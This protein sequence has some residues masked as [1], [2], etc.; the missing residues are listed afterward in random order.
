MREILY[1]NLTSIKKRRR[2]IFVSERSENK[3]YKTQ[4]SKTFVY[5]VKRELQKNIQ[6]TQPIFYITKFFNSYTQE[7]KFILRVKGTFFVI[8]PQGFQEITFCHSMRI[9]IWP[10]KSQPAK[11]NE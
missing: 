1:K 8:R 3:D 6:T 4:T 2:V 9:H 10:K 5:F 11:V 7:E